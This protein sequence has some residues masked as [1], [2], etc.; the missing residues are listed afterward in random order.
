MAVDVETYCENGVWK[1]RWRHSTKPFAVGRGKECQVQP[2][3]HR[4]HLVRRLDRSQ[5]TQQAEGDRY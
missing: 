3:R 4:G 1:T 2:R 5:K